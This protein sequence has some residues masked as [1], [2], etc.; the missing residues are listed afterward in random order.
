MVAA[1]LVVVVH[2]GFLAYLVVGGFLALR[3]FA[4]IWPHLGSTA[5]AVYVTATGATCPLTSLE[6][7]LLEQGGTTPY[8]ESFIGHYLRG[9]LYPAQYELVACLCA[10]GLALATYVVVFR[11]RRPAVVQPG[12]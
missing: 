6:K 10:I 9:T 7:W 11:R 5:W 1:G 2:M 8:E 12:T 4:S 3:W